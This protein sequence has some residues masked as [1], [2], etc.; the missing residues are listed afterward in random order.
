MGSDDRERKGEI[1]KGEEKQHKESERNR[2]KRKT[3]THHHNRVSSLAPTSHLNNQSA[4]AIKLPLQ[5]ISSRDSP[6]L[7]QSASSTWITSHRPGISLCKHPV[8]SNGVVNLILF[9]F[10]MELY[11]RIR[12]R[13]M[14]YQTSTSTFIGG[15]L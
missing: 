7:V 9:E 12:T 6:N 2:K 13:G 15:L 5:P 10:Q 4:D 11:I 14:V 1:D 3:P 8:H